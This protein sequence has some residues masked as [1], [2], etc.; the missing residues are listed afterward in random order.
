MKLTRREA[1]G[2]AVAGVLRGQTPVS[3]IPSWK[4]ELRELAP[5]VFA[6]M[7]GGGPGIANL[8]VS[9][10]GLI[11]GPDHMMAIDSLGAPLHAKAF[12]AATRL[13]VPGKTFDRLALTHHHLD[14]IAGNQY[15]LPA[16][17]VGHTYCRDAILATKI[18]TPLWEKRAGWADGTEDRKLYPPVTTFN[19]TVTYYYGDLAVELIFNG[20]A[21]TWGDVMVYV[22]RHR[23]LFAGDIAFHY[24]APFCQNAHVTKWLLAIDRIMAMDVD[25]VVPGHGPIGSKKELGEMAA[26]LRLFKTEARKRFDAGMSPG[27]AAA[28][29]SLGRFDE[30]IGAPEKLVMNT[31]RLY[32]EFDGTILPEVDDAGM[33]SATAEFNTI[34]GKNR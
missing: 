14:H 6:Y 22:P 11:A 4:T 31:V 12:I 21:H 5:G 30:W 9:N 15:F 25:V 28:E 3:A 20:P 1:I 33:R 10:A 18:A 19:D 27:Q 8:S 2:F 34:R 13:A 17:I 29:I 32:R 16:E 24:V 23:I 7:Q 26:Y